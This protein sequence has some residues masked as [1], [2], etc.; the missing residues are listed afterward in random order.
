MTLGASLS[1]LSPSSHAARPPLSISP[2]FR[3]SQALEMQTSFLSY[4][5]LFIAIAHLSL[6]QL[7]LPNL[8]REAPKPS[9]SLTPPSA[10]HDNVQAPIMPVIPSNDGDT[11][12]PSSSPDTSTHSP[13][14]LDTLPLTRRINIFSSLLRDHPDLPSLLSSSSHN[15]NKDQPANF[16]ILAPLNSALQSL[17]H[18]P[19]E[20]SND[21]AAFGERAY[22]GQGGQERAKENLKR[23]VEAHVVPKSPWGRGEKIKTLA[24]KEVWWEEK[25]EKGE[26]KRVI[27]PEGVEVE[28]VVSQAGNGE[29]W[30]LKKV[31][32]L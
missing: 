18:K 6:C 25:G 19:W 8:F 9:S 32:G 27:M 11:Q 14:L 16:T 5:T 21:Y 3:S 12:K 4:G 2:L 26:K 31:L 7:V 22:D 30:V 10:A 20:D 17:S 15:H 29:I 13:T 28:D 1:S 23:F 24:G